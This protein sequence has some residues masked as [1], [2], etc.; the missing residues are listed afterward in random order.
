MLSDML[1]DVML[2]PRHQL[3]AHRHSITRSHVREEEWIAI[4]QQLVHRG[5]LS[6]ISIQATSKS[7]FQTTRDK[8]ATN[9]SIWKVDYMSRVGYGHD[10]LH[11]VLDV[12]EW[13]LAIDHLVQNT[14]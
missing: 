9:A 12:G 6:L 2:H 13:G 11:L 1:D 14:S 7:S 4:G 5:S 3:H 10:P 8:D